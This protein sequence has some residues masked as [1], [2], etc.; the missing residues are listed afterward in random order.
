MCVKLLRYLA[1]LVD[2]LAHVLFNL[3]LWLWAWSAM[4]SER[5]R[6]R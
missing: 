2:A 5:R 3:S 6:E 4:V 1:R